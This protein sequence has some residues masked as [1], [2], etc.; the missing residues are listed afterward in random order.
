MKKP[1]L[2]VTGHARHGKDTVCQLLKEEHGFTF[3][4]SSYV[5]LFSVIYRA[6]KPKYKYKSHEECYKDR[7]NH[8]EEW[9]ELIKAYNTPDLAKLGREIFN[10]YDI[11]CGLRNMA[12]LEAMIAE[13]IVDCIVWVDASERLEPEPSTS[14]TITKSDCDFVVSNNGSLEDLKVEVQK[15]VEKL[16]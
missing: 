8:R 9:F 6:L 3:E 14:I 7:V 1:K 12:E 10:N 15:L 5:A 13:G 2:V 16:I 4:S 11:Y